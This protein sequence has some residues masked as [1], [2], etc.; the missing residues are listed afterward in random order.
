MTMASF[1][2]SDSLTCCYFLLAPEAQTDHYFTNRFE[3][4]NTPTL[5]T[6]LA[7]ERKPSE[8]MSNS[9]DTEAA[10]VLYIRFRVSCL[11]KLLEY[12]IN[13]DRQ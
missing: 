2:V 10:Y 4:I 3:R 13:V 8:A 12:V 9:R 6:L 11:R 1:E 7:T 5:T